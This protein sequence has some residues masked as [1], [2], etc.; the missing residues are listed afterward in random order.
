M[1]RVITRPRREPISQHPASYLGADK[2]QTRAIPKG[3]FFD[4]YGKR[5]AVTDPK[6]NRSPSPMEKPIPIGGGD[7]QS[8]TGT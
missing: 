2:V 7:A 8:I 1:R 4:V 5:F 6:A 3:R